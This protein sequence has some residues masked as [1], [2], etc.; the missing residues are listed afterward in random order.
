MTRLNSPDTGTNG[1]A[2]PECGRPAIGRAFPAT[3]RYLRCGR[4]HVFADP[5]GEG[6]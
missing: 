6:K 1:P 3:D 2:C 5:R 4:G